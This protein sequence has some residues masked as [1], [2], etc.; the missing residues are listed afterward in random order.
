MVPSIPSTPADSMRYL[1]LHVCQIPLQ[2]LPGALVASDTRPALISCGGRLPEFYLTY[3]KFKIAD[4]IKQCFLA[5]LG[6]KIS[7]YSGWTHKY[8]KSKNVSYEI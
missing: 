5:T 7:R 2:F 4:N 6:N 1:L 3:F 8:S